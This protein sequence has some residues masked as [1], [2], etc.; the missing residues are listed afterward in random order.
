MIG[1]KAWGPALAGTLALVLVCAALPGSAQVI[2][3]PLQSS[4][5]PTRHSGPEMASGTTARLRALDKV[6]GEAIDLNVEVGQTVTYGSLSVLLTACRYP[7]DNPA[8]DAFAFLEITD[9][10][11]NERLFRGWMVAS[12]PALNALDH[13]RYDVWVMRCT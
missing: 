12:S 5:T 3:Q 4:D 2:W 8:S 7:V 10:Q 11:R 13:P 9:T 1:S 6:S